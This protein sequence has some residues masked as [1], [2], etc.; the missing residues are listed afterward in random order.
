MIVKQLEITY[1]DYDGIT[2]LKL[3][4][5]LKNLLLAKQVLRGDGFIQVGFNGSV[6]EIPSECVI[7]ANYIYYD[8]S[9]HE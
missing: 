4:G 7:D 1:R 5:E 8:E 6:I 9:G 3:C 2:S